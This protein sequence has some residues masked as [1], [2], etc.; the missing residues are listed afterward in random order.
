M[1]VPDPR[2]RALRVRLA[3]E[4]YR[5]HPL[6]VWNPDDPIPGNVEPGEL[7]KWY[8][9]S[10]ALCAEIEAWDEE[11][12]ETFLPDDP[13]ES[14]FADEAAAERWDQR[15]RELARRLARELGPAIPVEFAGRHGIIAVG[16]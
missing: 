9:L 5:V 1:T 10:P 15:G 11:F 16:P 14:G 8:G 6:W 12:Q 3:P 4:W 7:G 13:M 2:R